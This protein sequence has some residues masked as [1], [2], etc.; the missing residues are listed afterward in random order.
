MMHQST[1]KIKGAYMTGSI[2]ASKINDIDVKGIASDI[3]LDSGTNFEIGVGY[4]LVK[5]RLDTTW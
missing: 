4:D 1:D 3:E 5:T 2:G